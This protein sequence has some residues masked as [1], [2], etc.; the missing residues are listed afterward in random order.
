MNIL[1]EIAE[2]TK[3]RIFM[4]KKDLPPEKIIEAVFKDSI[5]YDFPFEKAINSKDIAFICEIK[6]ASPS[7]GIIACNFPYLDIARDYE[8]AGAQAISVLTEP[9]WFKGSDNYLR[10]IANFA[11]IPLLRK[12]FI[13]DSY[14]IYQARLLGASAVLFICSI[15]DGETLFE[16]INIAHKI[17]L[18]ALV[19][20]HSEEEVYM[21]LS[22][23]ARV[24]GVNNR[25]LKDF[26]TDMSLSE[27]LR[28]LVPPGVLF[29][30]ESGISSNSD[31]ISLRKIKA[32]AALIGEALMLK[33]DK[34]KALLQ[35]RGEL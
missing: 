34:K 21:A 19:E 24:I 6:R 7:K 25:N 15:L 4:Q 27:R 29:V 20:T 35:L 16:Y 14:M 18:S 31:I 8:E 12:D 3:E 32:N 33:E 22:A 17:G 9:Y 11:G 2:R 30:S 10:R 13:V 26:N 23:G 1:R 5:T 28:K